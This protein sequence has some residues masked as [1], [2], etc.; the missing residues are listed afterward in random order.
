[1]PQGA[2]RKNHS[3]TGEIQGTNAEILAH[4][5]LPFPEPVRARVETKGSQLL[6]WVPNQ[7]HPTSPAPVISMYRNPEPSTAH[8]CGQSLAKYPMGGQSKSE[9]DTQAVTA[10]SC[11]HSTNNFQQCSLM[12]PTSE[13]MHSQQPLS[14]LADDGARLTTSTPTP[15]VAEEYECSQ[16]EPG[17]VRV[18]AH[19]S[20]TKWAVAEVHLGKSRESGSSGTPKKAKIPKPKE[21]QLGTYSKRVCKPKVIFYPGS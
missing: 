18:D 1:M 16:I 6:L 13:I 5:Q 21:T 12:R 3:A 11:A 7:G 19:Q 2:S 9:V 14:W 8:A 4:P 15:M 10:Q 17:K 20:T